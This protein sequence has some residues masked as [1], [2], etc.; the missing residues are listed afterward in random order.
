VQNVWANFDI[1]DKEMEA[2]K[3]GRGVPVS[4]R[5]AA[6]LVDLLAIW[7]YILA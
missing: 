3:Q 5:P 7:Q 1:P 2:G 6:M 4:S